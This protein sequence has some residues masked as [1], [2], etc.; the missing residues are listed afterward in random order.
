MTVNGFVAID[1]KG[2][3]YPLQALVQETRVRLNKP[4]IPSKTKIQ[5]VEIRYAYE[6]NPIGRLYMMKADCRHLP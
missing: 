4:K 5:Y 6:N 3:S 1:A 2:H